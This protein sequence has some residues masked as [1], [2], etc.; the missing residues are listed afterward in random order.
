MLKRMSSDR[1]LLYYLAGWIIGT[2]LVGCSPGR[3]Y[4]E[5]EIATAWGAMATY[6]THHT[7][8]NSPTYASRCL[9]YIGVTMYES[10]VHGDSSYQSLAGQLNELAALPQPEPGTTYDWPAACNAG[11]AGILKLIYN[12]TSD[13]NKSSIDSLA[14]EIRR[15]RERAGVTA[16]VLARSEAFGTAVAEA[17]FAWSKTDGGH[18]AYL[19]NFE[20]GLVHPDRP[21]SWQPPLYAQSF[22]HHPLHPYWGENRTFVPANDSLPLPTFIPYDTAVGSPYYEQFRAVYEQDLVLTQEQKEIAIWWGDDPDETFTPPGH[23][24]YIAG[25]VLEAKQPDLVRCAE[26]YARVGMAVA[27]AFIRCWGW[28]FHFFTE[29]PNT[30]IPRFIDREWESFWPDPPFPAFPSGHAIQA[31]AMAT[32]LIDLYGEEFTFTDRSHVGRPRDEIRDVDFRERHFTR[33][34]DVALE[35]ADSRFYGGIHTPQDNEVGL[36]GGALVAQHVN[37]LQWEIDD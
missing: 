33:F 16:E 21:G 20:K 5:T 6:I 25:L 24:F 2:L 8:S 34:W 35:T 4:T 30:Y 12:Q 19:R 9:G 36:E 22:S 37:E 23:S 27:D 14:T 28:K 17:I 15:S 3:D 13:A 10:V 11:Q 18:R 7:P 29:R 1:S 31:A 32:V 26:T